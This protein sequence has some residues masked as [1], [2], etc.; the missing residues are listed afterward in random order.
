M[1]FFACVKMIQQLG[2]EYVQKSI[3]EESDI[4]PLPRQLWCSFRRAQNDETHCE[5]GWL[6]D[7]GQAVTSKCT[8]SSSAELKVNTSIM[9]L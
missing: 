6:L 1:E 7:E 3:R 2:E 9:P 8:F 4:I 5:V